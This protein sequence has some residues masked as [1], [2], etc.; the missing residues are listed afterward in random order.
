[1]DL[2]TTAIERSFPDPQK[3]PISEA[4]LP[5]LKMVSMEAGLHLEDKLLALSLITRLFES[6]K[7]FI[8][9]Y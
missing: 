5:V 3:P 1:M 8:G 2:E 7:M 4:L 6:S 9:V